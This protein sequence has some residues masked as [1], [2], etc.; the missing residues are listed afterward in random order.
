MVKSLI[1][2]DY[3]KRSFQCQCLVTVRG[4]TD[5]HIKYILVLKCIT[6]ATFMPGSILQS[7]QAHKMEVIGNTAATVLIRNLFSV[8][9]GKWKRKVS[10]QIA[11]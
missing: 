2:F 4:L 7:F 8:D 11:L 3:F 1:I 10:E 9:V 5:V 6:F